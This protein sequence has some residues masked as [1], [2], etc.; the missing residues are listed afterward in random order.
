MRRHGG[1]AAAVLIAAMIGCGEA[2]RLPDEVVGKTET[3]GPAADPLGPAPAA[4]DPQAKAALDRAVKAVTQGDP[5][6]LGR[7]K[8]T[9]AVYK[10]GVHL[11]NQ[12]AMN[13]AT[14]YLEVEWPERARIRYEFA[15]AG[16]PRIAFHMALPNGWMSVGGAAQPADPAE[17][18]KIISGGLFAQY[19]VGL[20]LPLADPRAVA[21]LARQS[22]GTT[23]VKLVLPDLPLMLV[24]FDDKTGLPIRVESN[25][26]EYGNRVTKRITFADHKPHDGLVVPTAIELVQN[27]RPAE[28][29][30]LQK[31]ES[32]EKIDPAAFEPPK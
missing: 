6:R 22:D 25:P 28:K 27:G 7:V 11:P 29:W 26:L 3:P 32:P 15:E 16:H 21:A 17:M 10:G 24:T 12:P 2:K 19:G 31:W 5:A 14:L 20:G 9:A 8:A 18:G 30:T 1:P 23:G 4:S 13:D